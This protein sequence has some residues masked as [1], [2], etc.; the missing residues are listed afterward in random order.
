MRLLDF[1]LSILILFC[2]VGCSQAPRIFPTRSAI[3]GSASAPISEA[4]L[5]AG[6]NRS[7]IEKALHDAPPSQHEGMAFLVENMPD[8]DLQSLGSKYLLENVAMAYKAFNKA[9]WKSRVPKQLFL[10]DI[11]PYACLSEKRDDSRKVL[12]DKAA[13]IVADCA[14]PGE[15]AHRLNQ[16]LFPLLRARYSM[17]QTR[18]DQSPIE[19]IANGKATCVG[20]AVL[21]VD[22]CRAVGIPARVVS[23]P[24][25]I[26][27]RG[28]HAWVEIWDGDWHFAGA[29][30]PNKAGL[31][32]AWF[33]E[34]ASKAIRDVPAFAIYASSFKKTGLAFPLS[35]APSV[36]WVS[37]ENVTDRYAPPPKIS[38]P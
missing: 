13:P 38:S 6:P 5:R 1:T 22:A 24:T 4:L 7:E 35:W 16:K 17:N 28:T 32:H 20:L 25:W 27:R 34:I 31:D 8:S 14:S 30:E 26:D 10:N 21:L 23:T 37:A 36:H 11:L 19:T 33:N 3:H 2:G 12:W 18:G 29:A 15:S 9:K